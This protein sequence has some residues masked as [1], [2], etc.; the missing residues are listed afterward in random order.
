MILPIAP[1]E[2]L[3][4]NSGAERVSNEAARELADFLEKYAMKV[5][6]KALKYAKHAGRK[7]ITGE[8]IYLAIGEMKNE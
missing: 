3:I 4:R 1:V 6:A 5:A 2:R 8:D 7:T